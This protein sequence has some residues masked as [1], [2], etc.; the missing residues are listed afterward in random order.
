MLFLLLMYDNTIIFWA[1]MNDARLVNTINVLLLIM[2]DTV[3]PL[4]YNHIWFCTKIK[5]LYMGILAHILIFG[6]IYNIQNH[7]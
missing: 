1:Y 5:T 7:L 2:Y 4:F 3:M 6:P